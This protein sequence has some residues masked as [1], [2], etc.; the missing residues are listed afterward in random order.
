LIEDGGMKQ[1]DMAQLRFKEKVDPLG[2]LNP[3]KMRAW[4]ERWVEG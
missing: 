4:N 2:L 1:V 3:G